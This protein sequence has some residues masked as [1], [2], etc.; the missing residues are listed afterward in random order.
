M[1]D[2]SSQTDGHMLHD[3]QKNLRHV[4][5][6]SDPSDRRDAVSVRL[7]EYEALYLLGG[8]SEYAAYDAPSED[9]ADVAM[10]YEDYIN[11][12]V[13]ELHNG[14]VVLYA[15]T[16]L[17]REVLRQSVQSIGAKIQDLHHGVAENVE[18]SLKV[19]E[20]E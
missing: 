13:R 8:L 1:I 15:H 6:P 19:V 11:H 2:D 7:N 17:A 14:I 4:A 18:A 12:Q 3:Y 10:A 16:G 20:D 9:H 5:R